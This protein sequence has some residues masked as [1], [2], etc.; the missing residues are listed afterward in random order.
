MIKAY[1][2]EPKGCAVLAGIDATDPNHRIQGGGYMINP[3]KM[4]EEATELLDGYLQVTD[5]ESME[6][7]RRL[8][9]EEGIFGG[10]SAGANLAGAL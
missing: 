9:K 7:S 6:C 2:I 3:L 10:F 8:A 5:E 1:C 4:M